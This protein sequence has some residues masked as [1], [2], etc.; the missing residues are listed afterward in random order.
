MRS[1]SIKNFFGASPFRPAVF[2]TTGLV[3]ASL[4]VFGQDPQAGP[5]PPPPPAEP[6][7]AQPAPLPQQPPQGW[8]RVGDPANQGPNTGAPY[9]GYQTNP[10]YPPANGSNGGYSPA[11]GYGYPQSGGYGYPQGPGPQGQMAP[12]Q[13]PPIPAQLTLKPGT[14][15]TVRVNQFLSSDRNQAGDFFSATLARPIVVDGVVVASPGQTIGGHVAEAVKAGRVKGVSRLGLELTDLT[16]VDGQQFP[17]KTTLI[18]RYGPTSV[19]RDAGAIAG[20]TALGAAAGAAA[21]W[22]RGAAIGA[23]AGAVVGVVGVLLT[24]G[25]PTIVRPEQMLTFRV[26]APVTFSTE[27]SQAAFHFIEPGEF[28]SGGPGPGYGGYGGGQPG[29]AGYGGGQ[30]G[31]AGYGYA[32][33]PGYGYYAGYPYYGYPYYGLGYYPYFGVGFG[34]YG[35]GFYGYGRGFGGGFRGGRR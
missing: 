5:Q 8:P 17:I 20:T 1:F 15:V 12:Y 30:G 3:I 18:N 4:T 23:G 26:E 22:G 16:L 28:G 11:G 9:G 32:G 25:E 21:D 33:Y 14:Y 27:R 13:Q 24:R 19:G 10:G 35:R 29:Y 34:F 31:Y 7:Q 2:L 6:E